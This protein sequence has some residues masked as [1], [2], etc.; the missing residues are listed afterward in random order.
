MKRR[1]TFVSRSLEEF[2]EW[3]DL[4]KKMFRRI[5][6]LIREID[7]TPFEGTGKPERHSLTSYMDFGRV[8]SLTNID[9]FTR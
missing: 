8:E 6:A 3:S 9:W 7:R 1:V 2:T 4:E 5:A